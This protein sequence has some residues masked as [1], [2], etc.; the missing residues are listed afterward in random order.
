MQLQESDQ[1]QVIDTQTVLP[2]SVCAKAD[3]YSFS[4]FLPRVISYFTVQGTQYAMPFNTSGPGALLQQEGVHARR[5][6][7]EHSPRRRSPTCAPRPRSSRPTGWKRRSGSRPIPIFI[8]QWTAQANRLFANNGNGRKA[9]ATKAVFDGATG[10]QIFSWMDGMVKDGLAATN[11][12]LGPSQFDDLLG[13][14]S[15]SHAM[16]FD[17]SA[18]LGT[19]KSVLDAG[20]RP[21]HRARGRAASRA[22]HGFG[23]RRRVQPGRRAVHGEQVG[24]GEA[25]GGVEV[26][27]V[28]RPSPRT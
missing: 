25:G 21:Q 11:A 4:D 7:P 5:P 19:I 28:P 23:P 22:R 1:Q 8:E 18:A 2:A 20:E 10:N 9:R 14:R 13:I 15:G 27:E 6:R 16:A 3:K 26:P 17:T 24:A 12:D